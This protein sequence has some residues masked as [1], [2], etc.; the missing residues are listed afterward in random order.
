MGNIWNV[1]EK[2]RHQ[3]YQ[4]YN[5]IYK[6]KYSDDGYTAMDLADELG[7]HL[8][9]AARHMRELWALDLIYISDWDRN[10]QQPVPVMSWRTSGRQEDKPRPTPCSPAALAKRYRKRKKDIKIHTEGLLLTEND[11]I[12]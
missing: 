10:Y 4:V 6:L 1:A 12:I 8:K 11:S 7:L 9:T 3:K 2:G 5:L